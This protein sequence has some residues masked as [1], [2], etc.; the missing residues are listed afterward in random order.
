[1]TS[2]LQTPVAQAAYPRLVVFDV[3]DAQSLLTELR[4]LGSSAPY[5]AAPGW[6]LE[7]IDWEQQIPVWYLGQDIASLL[8]NGRGTWLVNQLVYPLVARARPYCVAVGF[9]SAELRP[10][11]LSL[12]QR[13]W[14]DIEDIGQLLL[15]DAVQTT[16]ALLSSLAE[17][18][19]QTPIEERLAKA[20]AQAGIEASPQVK[21]AHYR[22][23]FLIQ[24]KGRNIAVEADGAAY[25]EAERD[26]Q[27][28][29]ALKEL[30]VEEVIRFSGSAIWRD[31]P[32]CAQAVRR[33]LEKAPGHRAAG[34]IDKHLD[35]SQ[36]SAVEHPAGPARVLAPAGAG[37]TLTMVN[38]VVE[39]QERGVAASSILVL[40]FN[41]KAADQLVQRLRYRGVPVSHRL[42]GDDQGV[43]VMTFHAFGFR[44]QRDVVGQA[45]DLEESQSVLRDRMAEAV[46]RTGLKLQPKRNSDPYAQFLKGLARVKN[47]LQLPEDV[48]LEIESYPDDKN[49]VVDFAPV[50]TQFEKLQIAARSQ[51][52]DDLIYLAVLDLLVNPAHRELMQERFSYVLIDEYQDLNAAQLALADILSRP[53]RQLFVVGDDDQLIY[54]WRFA[55]PTNILKF[56][57]RMPPQPLSQTYTLSTNY[58]CSRA[59]VERST[60]LI[61]HNRLREPKNIQPH[62]KAKPGSVLFTDERTWAAR[63]QAICDFLKTERSRTGCSW[64]QLAVLCRYRAQQFL[65]ALALDA[66]EIPRTPLLHYRVFS[67]SAASLVRGYI[68]L[69]RSPETVSGEQLRTLLNRPN[70]YLRNELVARITEAAK[71]WETVQEIVND[72]TVSTPS[73]LRELV[74]RVGKLGDRHRT[75]KLESVQLVDDVLTE[76][77]LRRFWTD[78]A[79][80]GVRDADDAGA[81]QVVDVVRMLATDLPDVGAFLAAWD[82]FAE[83]ERARDDSTDD[84]LQREENEKQDQVVIGTIHAAKGREYQSVVLADYN[85]DLSRLSPEEQEEERRVLYVGVTRAIESV[86]L[87]IDLSKDSVH[88]FIREMIPP[89]AADEEASLKRASTEAREKDIALRAEQ[90]Q[91]RE[92][93][94]DLRSGETLQRA[95]TALAEQRTQREP[96]LA[97]LQEKER[98]QARSGVGGWWAKV[99]GEHG[100]RE[101]DIRSL[102]EQIER[103]EIQLSKLEQEAIVL[104]TQPEVARQAKEARLRQIDQ[105]LAEVAAQQVR[106]ISRDHELKLYRMA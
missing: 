105:E 74:N 5:V 24:H 77:E 36:L 68:Q 104:R 69:V 78:L 64:R 27:R 16:F 28:D 34:R 102:Q 91:I 40:A 60:R 32:A 101:H 18:V 4:A 96:L 65:V 46:K 42:Q 39:L 43:A 3:P 67:D 81:L 75:S 21:I 103:A 88:A 58:R 99:S 35:A 1:M 22:V 15:S 87:T 82:Q 10:R 80:K 9:G 49:Q 25:H 61:E 59:I 89:P 14:L 76:F 84:T 41:K 95:Q 85:P 54:G 37:K 33:S 38:R 56:H 71:P 86:Q 100:M 48:Q 26:A 30:G 44:Y 29:A 73:G 93:I 55:R 20:L 8:A 94:A 106:I 90:V 7:G 17:R 19:V 53:H 11:E 92:D 70:R 72:Q 97:Q 52:F 50:F 12:E 23:D 83:R 51:T 66:A 47:D 13:D 98:E 6:S 31:A 45:P 79:T 2:V 62:Q 57:D 63:A